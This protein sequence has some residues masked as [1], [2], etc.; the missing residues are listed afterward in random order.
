M[1]EYER[2][3]LVRFADSM[4]VGAYRNTFAA[5]AALRSL[6]LFLSSGEDPGLPAL[7]VATPT[8]PA[9]PE[10]SPLITD[11]PKT[12]LAQLTD[13]E[14]VNLR[15][16]DRVAYALSVARLGRPPHGCV[17]QVK[18]SETKMIGGGVYGQF[19][20][21]HVVVV[22]FGGSFNA[23][24]EFI[25]SGLSPDCQPRAL[26]WPADVESKTNA[27]PLFDRVLDGL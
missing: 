7:Q 1:T 23:P 27:I 11:A 10:R 14:F 25:D 3:T 19:R 2:A 16:L 13:A 6:V 26:M 20:K 5:S 18:S 12:P 17:G 22:V 21:A 9:A 15:R 4:L 8:P 24:F